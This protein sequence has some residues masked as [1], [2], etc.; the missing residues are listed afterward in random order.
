[1]PRKPKRRYHAR[2]YDPG[3][4]AL[5]NY[6]KEHP[7]VLAAINRKSGLRWRYGITPEQYDELFAKQRGLCASCHR[8]EC[9]KRQGRVMRLAVDHGHTTRT[10]RGLL[11]CKCNRALGLLEEDILRIR[12]LADYMEHH[13]A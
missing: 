9:I 7:E 10:V 1:M 6:Y 11:C 13:H 12:A 5:R 3:R 4:V 2:Y 8:P